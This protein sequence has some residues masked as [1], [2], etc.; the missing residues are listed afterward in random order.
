M[1]L[2]PNHNYFILVDDGS[3]GEFGKEINFR[4]ALE[5]EL[6]KEKNGQVTIPMV[7]IVVQGGPNTL[8]TVEETI[9]MNIPVVI[10]AVR[11]K[12]EKTSHFLTNF[13]KCLLIFFDECTTYTSEVYSREKHSLISKR[14]WYLWYFT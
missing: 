13:S 1:L 6:R 8:L 5:A 4:A 10:V 11:N 14:L 9:K 12:L 2:D 3:E 7:L